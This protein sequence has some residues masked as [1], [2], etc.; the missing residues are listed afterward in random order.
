MMVDARVQS[1]KE[2]AERFG[3]RILGA[4][5]QTPCLGMVVDS[6]QAANGII[7]AA[8][9]GVNAHGAEFVD[10][11]VKRGSK[12]VLTD[13]IGASII[14]A[15]FPELCVLQAENARLALAQIA[16]A[17]YPE[18]PQR[19]VAVTGTNGKTSTAS[20]VRQ[21]WQGLEFCAVNFGTAG[22]EGDVEAASKLTTPDPITLHE[23][24][25]S[26]STQQVTHAAM[27]ASSHGLD[28]YRLDG[29][30]LSVAG[31]TNLSRD[32]LDYHKTFG[33][34]FAAKA[35]LFDRVLPNSGIAVINIDDPFGETMRLVAEGRGQKVI[36]TGRNKTAMLRLEDQRFR[37]DG[38]DIKVNWNGVSYM[39][40]LK[41]VGDFQAENLLVAIGMVL[42]EEEVAAGDVFNVLPKLQSVRGRMQLAA[43]RENGAAVFVDYAHTPDALR[44]AIKAIRP[45]VMGKLI[46]VFGAGGDRDKGKRPLMGQV[47]IELADVVFVTDDN[48]R[49]EDPATIRSEIMAAAKGATEIG[50]RAE[51]ILRAVDAAGQGDVVLIAGKGHETGQIV[52]D[53]VLPFD[54][55]EQASLSVAVLEGREI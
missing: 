38:Q 33:D 26:L 29:V 35:T 8:M 1:P 17:F 15:K 41:L 18:T 37:E 45:H 7:F 52:G 22:V 27:E 32:H 5:A 54:D 30:K 50:D 34:Y 2:I 42:A 10:Q 55:V 46:T 12:V 9:P 40:R 53:H 13:A 25:A 20:F 19:I 11:A 6:R 21:I 3:L 36:T 4:G 31:Y 24:L 49:S 14:L 44:T 51:A 43:T 39:A 16:Q 28:Q 48:P 47:A 23:L